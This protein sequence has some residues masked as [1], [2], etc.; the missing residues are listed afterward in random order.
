MS[1]KWRHSLRLMAGFLRDAAV[2]DGGIVGQFFRWLQSH[3][4]FLF[5]LGLSENFDE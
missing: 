3:D 1:R 2:A 4:S 5:I